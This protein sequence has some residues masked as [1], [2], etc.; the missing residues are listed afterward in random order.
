[1]IHPH[2]NHPA[3][4]RYR[5]TRRISDPHYVFRDGDNLSD[6]LSPT[7]EKAGAQ[8]ALPP[9][10]SLMPG[11]DRCPCPVHGHSNG[12]RPKTSQKE[13]CFARPSAPDLLFAD[14]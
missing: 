13:W 2:E 12:S 6:E 10:T 11:H 3:L 8:W 9:E 4:F 1:M 14:I 5:N 7:I